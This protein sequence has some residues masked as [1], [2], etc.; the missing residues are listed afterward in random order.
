MLQSHLSSKKTALAL[1]ESHQ[2]MSHLNFPKMSLLTDP[3][4]RKVA[5]AQFMETANEL[6]SNRAAVTPVVVEVCNATADLL[7]DMVMSAIIREHDTDVAMLAATYGEFA[8]IEQQ[9]LEYAQLIEN[10]LEAVYGD[11]GLVEVH[12]QCR[13]QES[14]ECVRC[15]ECED[16][17]E[18]TITTCEL[19]EV[20]LRLRLDD[21]IDTISTDAYCDEYGHI[22]PPQSET[23]IT[24]VQHELNRPAFNAYLAAL[25][26]FEQ[27]EERRDEVCESCQEESTTVASLL[28]MDERRIARTEP[29]D[30]LPAP[31]P[32]ESQFCRN[33]TVTRDHCHTVQ[34]QLQQ[35]ACESRHL[36]TNYLSLYETAFMA[37]VTRYDN[38]KATVMILEADRKV[39]WDTIERVICLLMSLTNE[40]DGSAS[41]VATATLIDGCRNDFVDT[42]HLDIV[43][44]PTPEMGSLPTMPLNPCEEEFADEFYADLPL[45]MGI[46]E[47]QERHDHGVLEECACSAE[48]PV[49]E[50]YGFPYELGP[51]LLFNAGFELNSAEGFQVVGIGAQWTAATGGAQYTGRLSPF[52][53][54]TL[55]ELDAAFGLSGT[56]SV[57]QV[58]WAY[59]DPQ[60][61]TD[62]VLHGEEYP[63]TIQHRFV[64]TG[65]YVYRNAQGFVVALKEVAP[66]SDSLGQ[67]A[68]LT[69][70]FGEPLEIAESLALQACSEMNPTTMGRLQDSGAQAYC[71]EF[72]GVIPRCDHGCFLFRTAA[73]GYLAFPIAEAPE[74]IE[75][76]GE[77]PNGPLQIEDPNAR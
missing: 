43:Y 51:Y 73:H 76:P 41:S 3:S 64:R 75:H 14:E 19:L 63:E 18:E 6:A 31:D 36:A 65:G 24:Q 5:L 1:V 55:P 47:Y 74:E 30:A 10:S 66:S 72:S 54:V 53:A 17:C 56:D 71:W 46:G 57:A 33:F 38:Q 35:A 62:M 16:G 77:D 67:S 28:A 4:K 58:A 61:T 13:I 2:E 48:A 42:S 21:V 69:L 40:E 29:G 27:C 8:R 68:Q 9:R 7:R 70:F 39:E 25:A 34:R 23:V 50:H 22:Q 37:A 60:G 45:C 32:S 52:V 11:G 49:E 59:G 44:M 26:E 15:S 12:T 20:E